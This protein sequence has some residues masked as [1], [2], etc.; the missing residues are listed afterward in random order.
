MDKNGKKRESKHRNEITGTG[1]WVWN[2]WNYD[3][4]CIHTVVMT[5]L[6]LVVF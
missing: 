5:S 3:N 4:N 1:M 6:F 2:E